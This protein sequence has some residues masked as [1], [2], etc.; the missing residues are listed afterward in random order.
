MNLLNKWPIGPPAP[1]T[2]EDVESWH[3]P[4]NSCALLPAGQKFCKITQNRPKEVGWPGK[5]TATNFGQ[6]RQKTGR[7]KVFEE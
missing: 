4:H 6:N 3:P 7:K 2:P 1:S 5:M